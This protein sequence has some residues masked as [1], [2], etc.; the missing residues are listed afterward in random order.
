MNAYWSIIRP[1]VC[2]LAS[3]GVLTGAILSSAGNP[4]AILI[5][6]LAA[7]LICAGGNVIN[8]YYDYEIDKINKP[9]RPLPSGKITKKNAAAY[10]FQ[11]STIG[12][13]LAL[14]VSP[15]YFTIAI[16]NFTISTL[17]AWKLKKIAIIGNITDS[18]LAAVTF[19]S[20]ALIST[21]FQNLLTSP[22][23]ILAGIAFLTTMGREIYKDIEDT[24]GD[25]ALGAKTLPILIGNTA[26]M[27]LARIFVIL[28][29]AS[30]T[31]P[32]IHHVFTIN[33]IISVIPCIIILLYST[34]SKD[35]KKAQK[36]VKIGMFLGIIAF[37]IGALTG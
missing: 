20:G 1:N 12:S 8:D 21:G 7:F 11:L 37:L 13:A 33:Y 14:L 22:V 25:K 28:G 29:A 17:Y 35:P 16:L 5:A 36:T 9:K 27:N 10:Y 18:F 15:P 26:S 34:I 24:K 32:Y 31:I 30:A 19:L 6:L 3:I 23:L 4:T 2:F